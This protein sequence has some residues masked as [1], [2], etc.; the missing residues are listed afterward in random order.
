MRGDHRDNIKP[1]EGH[2]F[3]SRTN[4]IVRRN[5]S[6]CEAVGH[7]RPCGR[8]GSCRAL[9]WQNGKL[10]QLRARNRG[11]DE[12]LSRA[13]SG[14]NRHG[15]PTRAD[16]NPRCT[17]APAA[18]VS[19]GPGFSDEYGAC[20]FVMAVLFFVFLGIRLPFSALYSLQ[21]RDQRNRVVRGMKRPQPRPIV[22]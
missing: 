6:L 5:P 13:W 9:C 15:T 22:R 17:R 11:R 18:P 1:V 8:P 2:A 14:L 12:V 19:R 20:I 16:I 3:S 10:S 21:C 4:R 7:Y